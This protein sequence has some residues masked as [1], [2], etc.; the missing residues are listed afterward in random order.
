[1]LLLIYILVLLGLLCT[2][3]QLFV[4]EKDLEKILKNERKRKARKR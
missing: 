2:F 3:A 1:M 4:S